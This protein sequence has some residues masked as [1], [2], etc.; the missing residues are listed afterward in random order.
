MPCRSSSLDRSHLR[1]CFYTD[2][3]LPVGRSLEGPSTAEDEDSR[4]DQLRFISE[5]EFSHTYWHKGKA[6]NDEKMH[7]MYLARELSGDNVQ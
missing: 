3:I 6:T 2:S 7:A 5:K 4:L 1:L